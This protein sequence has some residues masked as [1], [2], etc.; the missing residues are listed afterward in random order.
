MFYPQAT[1]C[2]ARSRNVAS[3]ESAVTFKFVGKISSAGTVTKS[4]DIESVVPER[5][6][7]DRIGRAG[8]GRKID[9]RS[10]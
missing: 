8:K 3:D 10:T 5:D 9:D 7:V 2:C 6:I 4:G 1:G